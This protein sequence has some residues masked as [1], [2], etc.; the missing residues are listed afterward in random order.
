MNIEQNMDPELLTQFQTFEPGNGFPA[1]EDLPKARI[2]QSENLGRPPQGY[3]DNVV[4][5][6]QN[7]PG[8][9][10]APEFMV[11]YIGLPPKPL[12]S[13]SPV[14]CGYTEAAL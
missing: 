14:Y 11:Q 12:M 1:L 13:Y 6:E 3:F 4:I 8:S 2:L 5:K 9:D 7:I 10:G